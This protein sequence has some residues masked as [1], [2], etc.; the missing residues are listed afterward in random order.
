MKHIPETGVTRSTGSSPGRVTRAS[1]QGVPGTR[2]KKRQVLAALVL[3]ALRG[4]KTYVRNYTAG[5]GAE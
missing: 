3:D 1:V 4:A 2:G 5:R